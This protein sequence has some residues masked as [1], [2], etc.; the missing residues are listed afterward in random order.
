[1]LLP[2]RAKLVMLYQI[3]LCHI[4]LYFLLFQIVFFA[5]GLHFL[6]DNGP[7]TL[8]AQHL[9]KHYLPAKISVTGNRS[10]FSNFSKSFNYSGLT[11]I[12]PNRKSSLIKTGR[13]SK[14]CDQE[15]NAE[16]SN[17]LKEQLSSLDK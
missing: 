3:Q 5:N 16:V 9:H 6:L 8:A 17:G 10:F 15:L 12:S 1:M 4:D 14:L 13:H 11:M 7:L 2:I